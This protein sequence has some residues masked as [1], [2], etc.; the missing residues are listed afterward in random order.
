[1]KP[2]IHAIAGGI[3]MLL[4]ASFW[5]ST[6]IAEIWLGPAAVLGV[7]QAI[8]WYGLAAMVAAMACTGGSGFALG[9]A[10]K[11]RLLQRKQIRMRFAAGNGL[12]VMIPIALWLYVKAAAGEFDRS[13][14]LIQALELVMGLV[15]L[16]LL[17]LNARDGRR[18]GGKRTVHAS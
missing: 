5:C 18:L 3:A 14:Y 13:F 8:A 1:M 9:R 10:R 12:L 7:K 4:V 6:L 15:Q 16:T 11:G 2:A 17:G